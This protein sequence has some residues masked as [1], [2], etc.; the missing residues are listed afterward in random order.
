MD[1]TIATWGNSEAVRI[2][3]EIL[4]ITGLGKG[5]RVSVQVNE[6]GCIEIAPKPREHRRV[7]PARGITYDALFKNYTGGRLENAGA[8]PDDS[9]VGAEKDA[10]LS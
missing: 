5:D 8:W 6:K 7:A 4:R 1:T 2:P 9:L 10:W 3:R